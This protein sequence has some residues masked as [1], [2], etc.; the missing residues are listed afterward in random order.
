MRYQGPEVVWA[1][2]GNRLL[3]YTCN[4]V[5]FPLLN[6][7]QT[8]ADQV[9]TLS[10]SQDLDVQQGDFIQLHLGSTYVNFTYPQEGDTSIDFDL[11]TTALLDIDFTST[12]NAITEGSSVEV[13]RFMP[14]MKCSEFI[15]GAIRLANLM[16]SDPDIYGTVS[17]EPMRDF[18]QGTDKFTDISEEV[19]HDKEIEIRPSANEYAKRLSFKFKE[20]TETDFKKYEDKWGTPYGDLEFDQASFFAKGEQKI[21]LPFATILPYQIYDL[22][23]VPRFTD[24]DESGEVKPTKGAPRIMFRNGL[25]TGS[26]QL[27]GD[28]ATDNLT[29]YPSV[30]HFNDWEDPTLDLNFQLVSELYHLAFYVTTNNSYREYYRRFIEEIVSTDGKYVQLYRKMTDSQIKNLDWSKLLMWNGSLFRFNKVVDF[31]SEITEV[32]K[33]EMIKVLK[34]KKGATGG[35]VSAVNFLGS[36]SVSSPEGGGL[37]TDVISAADSNTL[38]YSK[39]IQG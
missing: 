14:D 21:E 10:I 28:S 13:R 2:G 3:Y 32:T 25:K 16:I 6:L 36:A 22:V 5:Q 27:V 12:Q 34:A 8:A 26:W 4:G 24:I 35:T 23:I 11:V 33:I 17:I 15:L 19:D 20:A 29:T 7:E 1:S 18:Y 37:G 31:D 39:I 38:Q 30:H 9:F